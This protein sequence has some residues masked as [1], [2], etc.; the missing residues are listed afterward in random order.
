M[1]PHSSAPRYPANTE[2]PLLS[3]LLLLETDAVNYYALINY[4]S[5]IHRNGIVD[6]RVED[7][8]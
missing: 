3:T 7:R 6:K 2:V 1:A 8:Q 4:F 5:D